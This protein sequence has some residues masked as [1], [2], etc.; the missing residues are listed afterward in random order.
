[1]ASRP[2]NDART[3]ALEAYL[4]DCE[5]RGFR[6]ESRT[7]TQAVITRN[8]RLS[9]YRKGRATRLVIWVDEQGTIET[10][11]IEARRW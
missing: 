2:E 10:R 11:E 8:H 4:A 1:M 9:R 5:S 7:N 6:L 3:A